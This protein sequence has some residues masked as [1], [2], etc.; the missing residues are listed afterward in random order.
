MASKNGHGPQHTKAYVAVWVTLLVL[1][2]VTVE[3]SYHDYGTWNIAVAMLIATIKGVL[4][5]LFFMHLKYD[6]KINQVIFI[7]GFVFLAIFVALTSSDEFNRPPPPAV[8]RVH[9]VKAPEGMQGAKMKEFLPSTPAQVA[10]GR[11]LFQQ[12]CATCHGVT[13]TGDGPAAGALNPKPR[14]FTN[15]EGWK[16]GRAPSQIFKTV[17]EGIPNTPMASFDTLSIEDRWAI[18]HFVSS[19]GPQPPPP[20]TPQSLAAIGIVEG[21]TAPAKASQPMAI[22]PIMFAME[23]MLAEKGK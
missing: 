15:P 1:T 21:E 13:G 18:T 3:I 16:N 22:L 12:N 10:K 17:T 5:C 14:N 4:V 7:S 6:N 11:D 2:F 20:D 23:R 8:A 9:P 19:L